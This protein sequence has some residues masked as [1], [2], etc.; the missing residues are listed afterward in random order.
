MQQILMFVPTAINLYI[1]GWF[2]TDKTIVGKYAAIITVGTIPCFVG[3]ALCQLPGADISTLIFKKEWGQL[4]KLINRINLITL[5]VAFSI[6]A[7]FCVF[8]KTILN[9][10]GAGYVSVEF[11]FIIFSLVMFFGAITRFP[12][13]I[14]GFS[15]NEKYV[16][17]IGLLE[18]P[19]LIISGIPLTYF[20][21]LVGASLS[22]LITFAFDA[23]AFTK[24]VREKVGIKP[25]SFF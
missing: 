17:K 20:F 22:L 2:A 24:I 21:G 7:L 13:I 15:K 23:M 10:F 4:Q 14:T 3:V 18:L 1:V 19:I 16:T 6:T 11:A 12:G 8:A 5:L 9:S 25:L